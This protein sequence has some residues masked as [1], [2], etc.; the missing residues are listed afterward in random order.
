[1]LLLLNGIISAKAGRENTDKIIIVIQI[2]IFFIPVLYQ[3][4]QHNCN[5]IYKIHCLA[6][7]KQRNNNILYEYELQLHKGKYKVFV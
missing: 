4:F 6:D 2:N 7:M 3:I 1:M 5:L